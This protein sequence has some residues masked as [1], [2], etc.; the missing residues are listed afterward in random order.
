M[1][2]EAL[3]NIGEFV[4]SIGVVLSLFYLAIQVRENTKSNYAASA[5]KI[6]TDLQTF[7]LNIIKDEKV[8]R[9]YQEYICSGV[10]FETI[11]EKDIFDVGLLLHAAFMDCWRAYEGYKRGRVDAETWKV[12]LRLFQSSYFVSPVAKAWFSAQNI[13]PD[14]FVSLVRAEMEMEMEAT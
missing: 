12:V 1:N 7:I 3:G 6:S 11:A 2:L 4:G 14:D 9:L 13:Y 5:E 10:E 8:N